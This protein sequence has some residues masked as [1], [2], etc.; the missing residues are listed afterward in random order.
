MVGTN[1][2]RLPPRRAARHAA[3]MSSMVLQI[4]ISL[5]FLWDI[6]FRAWRSSGSRRARPAGRPRQYRGFA[7]ARSY[8]ASEARGLLIHQ[9]RDRAPVRPGGC[10][11]PRQCIQDFL[12]L[13]NLFLIGGDPG[14]QSNGVGT[15]DEIRI[16]P[17]PRLLR[18]RDTSP[19]RRRR[20]D[21]NRVAA[22][23]GG[24]A[25]CREQA[26]REKLIVNTNTR[27][28]TRPACGQ[29]RAADELTALPSERQSSP[30]T[31]MRPP[32]R[33][34]SIPER[35]SAAQWRRCP[36]CCGQS[37]MIEGRKYITKPKPK[38]GKKNAGKRCIIK[39]SST[40]LA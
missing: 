33:S 34:A 14:E 27:T 22:S 28:D 35:S 26:A 6:I 5:G 19:D 24:G 29:P 15:D 8:P 39:T 36:V 21:C 20:S 7:E 18:G 1:P 17:V 37:A 10:G 31:P 25:L 30:P 3:R 32:S 23:G 40:T 4:L 11:Q 12:R 16:A 9:D 2:N 38:I 13:Q